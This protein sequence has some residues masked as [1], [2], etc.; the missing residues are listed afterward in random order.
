MATTLSPSQ[1][2]TLLRDAIDDFAE[3]LEGADEDREVPTCPG[4]NVRDLAVHLGT[5]HRWVAAIVL[6]G[7]AVPKPAPVIRRPLAEW[8]RSVADAMLAAL[9]AAE[10]DEPAPNFAEISETAAFWHRRQ[11]HEVT[12]H[13]HDLAQA[14]ATPEPVIRNEV[15]ADGTA[16]V[17]TVYFRRLQLE[18]NPP[19]LRENIRIYATDTGD[20][21][22]LVPGKLG[23]LQHADTPAAAII[24]G[25]ARDLYLGFWGRVPAAEV[26][27]CE[28]AAARALL[29]GPTCT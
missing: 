19:D 17:L 7:T 22:V 8:Y 12:I 18:G 13:L 16:E 10:L 2:D 6:S 25:A 26:L 3:L 4:W 20:R 27:H 23:T 11:L 21:W 15:A 24:S 29:A 28:G 5:V 14:L 1:I 9:A